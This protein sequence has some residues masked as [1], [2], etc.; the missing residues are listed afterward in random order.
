MSLREK[1]NQQGTAAKIAVVAGCILAV[2]LL[3]W[4]AFVSGKPPNANQ[5]FYTSDDGQTTFVDDFFRAYPFDHGGKPAYRAYVYQTSKGTRFV[6]Y[7]ERYTDE[8]LKEL[9]PLLSQTGNREQLRQAIQAV[10]LRHT[11]VKKPNDPHAKWCR[12]GSSKADG[13]EAVK[14]P[15]GPDDNC[16]LVF[17]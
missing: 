11:E 1:L 17:P 16:F 5:A 4:S 6:G 7:L 13:V 3:V 10:R 14:S 15:D 12:V 2:G 9:D 8:G